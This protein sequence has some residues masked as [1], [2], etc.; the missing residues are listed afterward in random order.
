MIS[1]YCVAARLQISHGSFFSPFSAIATRRCGFI[2]LLGAFAASTASTRALFTLF[3]IVNT[4]LCWTNERP[5]P[6]SLIKYHTKSYQQL[7]STII[8]THNIPQNCQVFALYLST[9][10]PPTLS[11]PSVLPPHPSTS[12]TPSSRLKPSATKRFLLPL[13]ILLEI[14]ILYLPSAVDCPPPSFPSAPKQSI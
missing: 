14:Y 13:P 1:S 2:P 8:T 6:W 12:S 3:T 10:L 9:T 7:L 5:P 11:D 4:V